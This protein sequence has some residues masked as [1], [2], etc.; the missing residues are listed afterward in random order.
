[1]PIFFP[2]TIIFFKGCVDKKP[3]VQE[4]EKE[5]KSSK[6]QIKKRKANRGII[7]LNSAI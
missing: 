3:K 6:E 1:M 2:R 4:N 5:E 7:I